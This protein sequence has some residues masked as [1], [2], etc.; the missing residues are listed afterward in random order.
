MSWG[1]KASVGFASK[2]GQIWQISAKLSQLRPSSARTWPNSASRVPSFSQNLGSRGNFSGNA[3]QL[4]AAASDCQQEIYP[5]LQI[6]QWPIV[7]HT[8]KSRQLRTSSPPRVPESYPQPSQRVPRLSNGSRHIVP[9]AG[10]PAAVAQ[11]WPNVADA[12]QH[13]SDFDP[14]WT[15]WADVGRMLAELVQTSAEF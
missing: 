3:G 2:S 8:F 9:G 7:A 1:P 5:R 13:V 4:G 14:N 11:I 15:L 10:F 6:P 12:G